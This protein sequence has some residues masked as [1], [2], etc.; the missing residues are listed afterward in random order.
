MNLYPLEHVACTVP[1]GEPI[2]RCPACGHADDFNDYDVGGAEPDHLFC[3]QCGTEAQQ[4]TW[5]VTT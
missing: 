5:E 2:L 4:P 1:D 3:N